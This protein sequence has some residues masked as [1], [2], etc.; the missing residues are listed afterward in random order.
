M[1]GAMNPGAVIAASLAGTQP[2]Q[3]QEAFVWGQGGRRMTPEAIARA[4][5]LAS[6]QMQVDYSPIYSPWQGAARVADNLVGA[7][8]NRKVDKAERENMAYSQNQIAQLL[9]GGGTPSASAPPG[10]QQSSAP[11]GNMA[12]A[13]QVI[14]DPYADAGAKAL[15]QRQLSL[16]DFYAKEGYKAQHREQPEIVQLAQI[17]NDPTQP[18]EIKAA[19]AARI[20]VLND[21]TAIIPGLPIGTYVGPTSGVAAA[22]GGGGGPKPGDEVDGHRFLGGNPNDKASWEP[23][24]NDPPPISSAPSRVSEDAAMAKAR[25]DGDEYLRRILEGK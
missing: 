13:Q 8:Q 19:A 21:P 7:L 2:Q 3:P 15:A 24:S 5:D 9:T 4:R 11:G 18:P 25:A 14:A 20:K 12:L 1:I 10:V 23:V 17:A 6:Q 22:L 16:S